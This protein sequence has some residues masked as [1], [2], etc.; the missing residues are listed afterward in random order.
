[1][2]VELAESSPLQSG[3]PLTGACYLVLLRR[4]LTGTK[5]VMNFGYTVVNAPVAASSWEP[6]P[7]CGSSKL[8]SSL[9]H[10]MSNIY[11]RRGKSGE[12][13]RYFV[14]IH[15]RQPRLVDCKIRR[16]KTQ[17]SNN[18]PSTSPAPY[19][20]TCLDKPRRNRPERRTP[21]VAGEP[22]RY[23][24]DIAAFSEIQFFEQG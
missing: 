6:T 1:M 18:T 17:T 10:T 11:D 15:T 16:R 12:G 4:R 20:P 21:L 9:F 14:H 22:A 5:T 24:V 2:N 19:T 3:E 8:D 7:T 23:K 13:L